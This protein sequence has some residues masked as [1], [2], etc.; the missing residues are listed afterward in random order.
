[1][2]GQNRAIHSRLLFSILDNCGN[3]GYT[4][5][6]QPAAYETVEKDLFRPSSTSEKCSL[7]CLLPS[8]SMLSIIMLCQLSD[9]LVTEKIS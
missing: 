4:S 5:D 8:V 3:P 7:E 1:M 2:Y 6:I 9:C